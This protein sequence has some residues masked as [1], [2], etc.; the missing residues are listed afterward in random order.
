MQQALQRKLAC[1]PCKLAHAPVCAGI[2][3]RPAAITCGYSN[4]LSSLQ[5][6]AWPNQR[7]RGHLR[8]NAKTM[9]FGSEPVACACWMLS[10]LRC[11]EHAKSD[12]WAITWLACGWRTKPE[13]VGHTAQLHQI[14]GSGCPIF[15]AIGQQPLFK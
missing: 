6:L 15:R 7:V 1:K 5:L 8:G 12:F 13:K 3:L 2:L 9:N 14:H 4:Y 11:A 10:C